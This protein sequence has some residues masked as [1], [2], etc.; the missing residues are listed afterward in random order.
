MPPMTTR[1]NFHGK[2]GKKGPP[3][4]TSFCSTSQGGREVV[5][6]VTHPAS[7][8]RQG[9]TAEEDVFNEPRV[10][11]EAAL[12]GTACGHLHKVSLPHESRNHKADCRMGVE[13][14]DPPGPR[15][16]RL[17]AFRTHTPRDEDAATGHTQ[18]RG[19]GDTL[20]AFDVCYVLSPA[21]QPEK[22]AG[23]GSETCPSPAAG[24]RPVRTQPQSPLTRLRALPAAPRE[25][26]PPATH[27]GCPS[28]CRT[29][30]VHGTRRCFGDCHVNMH[31][32]RP[33]GATPS[34]GPCGGHRGPGALPVRWDL[35]GNRPRG[36][37]APD[38]TRAAH[39]WSDWWACKGALH[40]FLHFCVRSELSKS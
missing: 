18:R 28:P 31:L 13:Y 6:R 23:R 9:G 25:A 35:P 26:P 24:K 38:G 19:C 17:Q 5:A 21:P 34:A 40:A 27:S 12:S 30:E 22:Q 8:D 32:R 7:P 4:P 11:R 37:G 15:G 10:Q 29:C 16:V 33:R 36:G 39:L 20:Q 14:T 3:A 1:P 2:Q